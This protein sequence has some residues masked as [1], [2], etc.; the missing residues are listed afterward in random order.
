MAERTPAD[1]MRGLIREGHGLLKDMRAE[2]RMIEQLLDGIPDKVNKRI[3]DAV[4]VGLETLG[5]KTREAMDASVAK[6]GREFDRLE[7][8]FTG[9]ERKMHRQGK[10]PLEDLIREHRESGGAS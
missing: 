10:P 2:R 9:T 7:A 1:E 4:R 6:V 8:I 3:E 5:E